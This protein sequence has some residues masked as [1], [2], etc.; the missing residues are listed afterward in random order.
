MTLSPETLDRDARG[1]FAAGC[2]GNPAGKKPGTRNRATALRQAM[3]EGEEV[4]MAR[5]L[6]DKALAGDLVTARFCLDR[7][8]PR[9]RARGVVLDLPPE[10]TGLPAVVAAFNAALR[11]LAAGEIT[12]DEAAKIGRFLESRR[13]VLDAVQRERKIVWPRDVPPIPG[14]HRKIRIHLPS[15]TEAAHWDED[16][17]EAPARPAPLRDHLHST[18]I[19]GAAGAALAFPEAQAHHRLSPQGEAQAHHRLSPQGEAHPRHHLSPRGEAG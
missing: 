4:A 5:L 9:P 8:C 2:S 16:G 1:R 11:A 15:G 14:E 17:G 6:L 7:I 3:A 18:C 19:G 12:P 10:M 13:N